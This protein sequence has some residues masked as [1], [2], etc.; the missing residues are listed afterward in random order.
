MCWNGPK[1][2]PGVPG[3]TLEMIRK[4]RKEKIKKIEMSEID[5]QIELLKKLAEKAKN[6]MSK[7]DAIAFLQRVGILD[8]K[9]DIS[10]N[11]PIL[12]KY[13]E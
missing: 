1:G 12:K 11:Y 9:G 6:E 8:E 13:Y 4:E 7:D 2:T 3:I 10:D 5:R